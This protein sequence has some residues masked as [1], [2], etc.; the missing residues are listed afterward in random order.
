MYIVYNRIES[1]YYYFTEGF[2]SMLN[3][4]KENEAIW[5][6]FLA[7]D[8]ATVLSLLNAPNIKKLSQYAD[9]PFGMHSNASMGDVIGSAALGTFLVVMKNAIAS[10]P[11][12]PEGEANAE[13]L[14]AMLDRFNTTI[15]GIDFG[16]E[17]IRTNITAI[18]TAAS[19][20]PQPYLDIGYTMVG[21]ADPAAVQADID[22]ARTEYVFEQY[23]ETIEQKISNALSLFNDRWQADATADPVVYWDD[24][25]KATEWTQAWSDA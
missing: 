12:T 3:I 20:D 23:Y 7:E 24:A 15:Y 19:V 4:I 16:N 5:T 9:Q 14:S 2:L 25:S 10:Q 17:E 11:A 1:C 8:D 13:V 6:A 18:F 21:L 22:N